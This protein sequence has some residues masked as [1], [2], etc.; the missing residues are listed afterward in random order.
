MW[1]HSYFVDK[2]AFVPVDTYDARAEENVA[3]VKHR[4][5]RCET[6]Y[7]LKTETIAD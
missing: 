5:Q 3:H 6:K 7:F 4:S 1:Q 2:I